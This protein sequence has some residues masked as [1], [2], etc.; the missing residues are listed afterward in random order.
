MPNVAS[1]VVAVATEADYRVDPTRWGSTAVAAHFPGFKHLDMRTSGA[2]IR[3]RH[4]GS[5]PPLL[6]VHGNPQNH[7]CASTSSCRIS[8]ATAIARYPSPVPTMST[9]ASARW[10][11]TSSR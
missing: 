2:T 5:W 8:A 3:L 1:Q 10:R 7:T 6:L 11:V 9:S 4:G